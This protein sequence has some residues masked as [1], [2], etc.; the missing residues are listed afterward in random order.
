M[1]R[2]IVDFR[3]FTLGQGIMVY[4]DG[5]CTEHVKVSVDEI[6]DTVNGLREK[7][8]INQIDLCGNADY[9]SRFKAELSLKFGENKAEINIIGR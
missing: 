1:D 2:I 5:N 9:L 6:P 4:Q 3:P 7:Y 8:N